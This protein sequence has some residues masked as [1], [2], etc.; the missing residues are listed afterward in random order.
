MIVT[1][2]RGR[3]LVL[4]FA[5]KG[6]NVVNVDIDSGETLQDEARR[7]GLSGKVLPLVADISRRA[8]VDALI[9]R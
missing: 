7:Q 9:A 5:R 4:E 6:A 2:G 3:G 1:G 8:D